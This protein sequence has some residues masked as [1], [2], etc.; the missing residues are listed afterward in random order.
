MN[1]YPPR[2][3]SVHSAPVPQMVL[4]AGREEIGSWWLVLVARIKPGIPVTQ[5]QEAVSLMFRSEMIK[6]DKPI[7]KAENDPRI[8]LNPAT[9]GLGGSQED[10]LKPLYVMMLCVGVVLL[11]AC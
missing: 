2:Q 8:R 4:N 6:G 11:I 7:F 9:Q 10:K 5:A 3:H 1:L